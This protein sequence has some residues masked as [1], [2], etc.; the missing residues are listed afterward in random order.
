MLPIFVAAIQIERRGLLAPH[1]VE[2]RLVLACKGVLVFF[3]FETESWYLNEHESK[4]KSESDCF[5][6]GR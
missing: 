3:F 4:N 6:E 5:V 1:E 2:G